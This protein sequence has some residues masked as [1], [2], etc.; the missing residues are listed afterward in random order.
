VSFS[1]TCYEKQTFAKLTVILQDFLVDFQSRLPPP[2]ANPATLIPV[3]AVPA[4][5]WV[6]QNI[7]IPN[8]PTISI[9]VQVQYACCPSS[10]P[11]SLT[12]FQ[13]SPRGKF[14]S[15][16]SSLSSS[17]SSEQLKWLLVKVWHGRCE[18]LS[19]R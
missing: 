11:F 12:V 1:G 9:T 5:Q 6:Q 2:V 8:S 4:S 18:R 15:T 16:Y 7:C 14:T 10:L 13:E 17:M 19:V 3:V